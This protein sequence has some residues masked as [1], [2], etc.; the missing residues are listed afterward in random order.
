MKCLSAGEL[1]KA[2][3]FRREV[4]DLDATCEVEIVSDLPFTKIIVGFMEGI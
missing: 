2:H 1:L 3:M 4:D